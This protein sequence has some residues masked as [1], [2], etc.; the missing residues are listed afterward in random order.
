[1]VTLPVATAPADANRV[2]EQQPQAGNVWAALRADQPVPQ[3]VLSAQ[4]ENPAQAAPAESGAATAPAAHPVPKPA[5][6][7]T[8]KTSAGR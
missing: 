6:K 1:M 2:V 4:P 8:A 7:S 3:A 5:P